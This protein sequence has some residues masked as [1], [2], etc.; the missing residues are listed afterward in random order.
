MRL[1]LR[2]KLPF[3]TIVMVLFCVGLTSFI[4]LY[5]I[6]IDAQQKGKTDLSHR[7]KVM[8]H[9]FNQKG[10]FHVEGDSLYAGEMLV[11]GNTEIVDQIKD[12]FDGTATVFLGDLRVTTNVLNTNGERAI[13][14][15]LE[16]LVRDTVLNE[17][18][19]YYGKAR[20]LGKEYFTAYEPIIQNSEVIGILYTGVPTEIYYKAFITIRTIIVISSI[21][22]VVFFGIITTLYT[23]S[24]GN[25][26]AKSARLAQYVADGD[27]THTEVVKRTDELGDIQRSLIQ[28]T[29]TLR[30]TVTTMRSTGD[31]VLQLATAIDHSSQ[32]L[33]SSTEEQAASLEETT[34]SLEEISSMIDQNTEGARET[35][36]I[37][38]QSATEAEEGGDAVQKT[39]L[40][41]HEIAEKVGIIEDIAYQ[42]NLLA[43]NA[44]IEAARAGEHGRGF[45][46]VSSE[47][48]K[49]AE[50]SQLSA[51]EINGLL[52]SSLAISTHAGEMLAEIIPSIKKTAQLVQNI[53][54][55]SEQQNEGTRQISGGME[56]LNEITQE[57]SYMAQNLSQSA[58]QLSA[59]AQQLHDMIAKFII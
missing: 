36:K 57:N 47:V 38:R 17:K 37:A 18:K 42:T 27:L 45:T 8:R 44:A 2:I 12:L 32:S 1:T 51:K 58:V 21:T 10:E 4:S 41:M 6:G 28:M 53:A 46:V 20:I 33:S 26:M 49:L 43:L 14:T 13:G 56:Q 15:R 23:I 19:S 52:T 59:S 30:E 29:D 50:R 22:L 25:E 48:R 31:Q 55:A 35:D 39:V 16:G 40:A 9:L 5:Q 34:S 54:A 3:L 24:L 11:N 7:I